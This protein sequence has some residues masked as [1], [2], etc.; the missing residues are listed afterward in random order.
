MAVAGAARATGVGLSRLYLGVH[1]TTDVVGGWCLAVAVFA[2]LG[3][4]VRGLP[5]L[6]AR[7]PSGRAMTSAARGRL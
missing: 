7:A 3:L 1:W 6:A 2:A 5:R 4:A